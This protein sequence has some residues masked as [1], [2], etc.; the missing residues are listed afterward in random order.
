[1]EWYSFRK[2]RPRVGEKILV[3]KDMWKGANIFIATYL[4]RINICN[5]GICDIELDNF[6]KYSL[7]SYISQYHFF[8]SENLHRAR[9]N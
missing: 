3:A 5:T 9:L 1:M 7:K 4:G 8:A 6:E 2:K